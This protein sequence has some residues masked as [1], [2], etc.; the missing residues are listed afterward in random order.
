M[1]NKYLKIMTLIP[2]IVVS[3]ILMTSCSNRDDDKI[4]LLDKIKREGR[5]F[6]A[7]NAEFEPFEFVT[8]KGVEGIDVEISRKVAE[9]LGVELHIVDGSFTSV[10]LEIKKKRCGFAA[11]ALSY[12]EEK[13][14]HVDFSDP[15]FTTKQAIIVRIDSDIK[16]AKDLE[17][18]KIGVQIGTTGD[19]F[20]TD[21]VNKCQ[22]IRFSKPM[23]AIMGLKAGSLDAVVVDNFPANKFV[24]ANSNALKKLEEP[25]TTENYV[26][27]IPKGE[28]E[29]KEVINLVIAEL[30]MNGQLKEIVSKFV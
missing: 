7:T 18:K 25:L 22:V 13:E 15:Y 9:K 5:I 3:A 4:S 17:G 11:A 29:I 2:L 16:C 27:A 21:H 26:M 1:G 14:E 6:V 30:K 24:S 28:K 19:S 10:M 20:C 23:N 8:N 12:S